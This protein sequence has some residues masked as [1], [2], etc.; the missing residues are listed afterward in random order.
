MKI[1]KK[2]AK[3]NSLL[4][5]NIPMRSHILENRPLQS[6][7]REAQRSE[8]LEITTLLPGIPGGRAGL[9]NAGAE[10]GHD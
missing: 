8:S 4:L 3:S 9:G 5:L 7:F 1:V 2:S 10:E 6:P